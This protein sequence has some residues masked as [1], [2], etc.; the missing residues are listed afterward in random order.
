MP[1]S[2][3]GQAMDVDRPFGAAIRAAGPSAALVGRDRELAILND[4]LMTTRHSRGGLVLISGEAGI[5]KTALADDLGRQS[6][7]AGALVFTGH[8]YDR[9]ESPP[10][11][12]WREIARRI[13]ALPK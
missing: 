3:S 12:P 9:A 7:E 6:V 13:E 5:G 8:C 4:R 10:Y 11:G 1:H 2:I